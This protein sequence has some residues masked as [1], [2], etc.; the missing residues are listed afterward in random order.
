MKVLVNHTDTTPKEVETVARHAKRV[1]K[2][3]ETE[4]RP[5]LTPEAQESY[6]INLAVK[7]AERQL[8]DGTA[9]SQVITHYLKLATKERELETEKLRN[10]NALLEAKTKSLESAKHIEE[11]YAEAMAAMKSYR[12]S[13]SAEDIF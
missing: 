13:A 9:S 5:M 8:K 3:D 7:C 10:E 2:E 6:M 4:S 12:S 1:I 11:L